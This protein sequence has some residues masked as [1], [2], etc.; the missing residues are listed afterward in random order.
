M[1]IGEPLRVNDLPDSPDGWREASVRL[2]E[3]IEVLVA[4]LRPA[5]PDRR[6]PKRRAA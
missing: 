4:S 1:R 6:R 2:M 5:V 3:A